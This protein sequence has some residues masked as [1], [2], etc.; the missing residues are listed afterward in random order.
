MVALIHLLPI[1]STLLLTQ[2]RPAD[3]AP[4]PAY[5]LAVTAELASAVAH[6]AP[7]YAPEADPNAFSES[8]LHG[9]L[10]NAATPSAAQDPHASTTP[11]TAVH[12]SSAAPSGTAVYGS[13]S[14][15]VNDL[16][17]CLAVS[18]LSS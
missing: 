11:A 17:S 5:S 18:N 8:K 10:W 16:N 15:P 4:A 3:P 14:M 7:T 9:L 12:D 13:G 6:P 2:A 1:L